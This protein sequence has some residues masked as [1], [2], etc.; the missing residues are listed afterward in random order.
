[1]ASI[2][3]RSEAYGAFRLFGRVAFRTPVTPRTRVVS[4]Q[5]KE[6][7]E[8]VVLEHLDTGARSTV[9]CDTVVTAGD[10]I[11][12]HELVRLAGIAFDK[13][14]LSPWSERHRTAES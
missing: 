4:I 13:A 10:W 9:A 7:V 12:D 1:M 6:R 14:T 2:C 3:D 8:S 5:G 11:P